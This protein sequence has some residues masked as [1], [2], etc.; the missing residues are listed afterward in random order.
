MADKYRS[1]SPISHMHKRS[2]MYIGP[3]KAQIFK[4]KW[5]FSNNKFVKKT[6]TYSPGLERLFIEAMSNAID[7]W[8]R[9]KDSNTPCTK[10]K[11]E[12]K[13]SGETSIWND[14]GT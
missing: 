1:L 10:I 12:I 3:V 7:N 13:D 11:I 9:S 14:G 2:E 5:I 4:D 8:E 6:V